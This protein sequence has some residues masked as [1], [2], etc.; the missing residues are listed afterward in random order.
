MLLVLCTKIDTM[1][2]IKIAVLGLGGVGGFYG[3]KLAKR[4]EDS[5]D[6]GVYFI[7]AGATL[8][9]FEKMESE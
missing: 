1:E 9:R 7:A 2:K 4:F 5:S 6:V 8:M 3:G